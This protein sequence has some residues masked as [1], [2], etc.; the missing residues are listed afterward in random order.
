MQ[1]RSGVQR[2]GDGEAASRGRHQPQDLG[3]GWTLHG[4]GFEHDVTDAGDALSL[5]DHP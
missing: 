3:E 2:A 1:L 5:P 4:R